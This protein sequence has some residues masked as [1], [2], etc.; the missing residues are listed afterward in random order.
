M[1]I[2]WK[3]LFYMEIHLSVHVTVIKKGEFVLKAFH[4]PGQ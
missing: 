4:I 1:A 3:F 2:R